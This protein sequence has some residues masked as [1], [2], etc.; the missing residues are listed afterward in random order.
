MSFRPESG[1]DLEE[2]VE[3][4]PL[5]ILLVLLIAAFQ[6]FGYAAY[7]LFHLSSSVLAAVGWFGFGAVHVVL[8]YGLGRTKRWSWLL[9]ITV[10]LANGLVALTMVYDGDTAL[11]MAGL[12]GLILAYLVKMRISLGAPKRETDCPISE[13]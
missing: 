12:F 7:G 10:Y 8:A 9:G 3:N 5:G 4:P 1:R 2:A 11:R 6:A 13:K